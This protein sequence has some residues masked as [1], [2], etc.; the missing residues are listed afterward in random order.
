MAIIA[1]GDATWVVLGDESWAELPDTVR[2]P[3]GASA[4]QLLV[5]HFLDAVPTSEL[6][7]DEPDD[8]GAVVAEYVL[9]YA[10]G[11]RH[12]LPIR[13]RFEISPCRRAWGMQ[14]FAAVEQDT[15]H[16]SPVVGAD[17]D[18]LIGIVSAARG[19]P[20]YLL[21]ALANPNP[22]A[23]IANIEFRA[24]GPRAVTVAALTLCSL[25]NNPFKRSPLIHIKAGIARPIEAEI[26]LG[27]VVKT[28]PFRGGLPD[29]WL[30]RPEIGAG[31]LLQ[32]PPATLIDAVAA[33]DARLTI[34]HDG[35]ESA[36]AWAE[37]IEKGEAATDDGAINLR[38]L[39]DRDTWVH[40]RVIDKSTG[41][42]SPARVSFYDPRGQ[43]LHPY[44]HQRDINI[45]WCEDIGGNFKLG[46][47]SF[48]YVDGR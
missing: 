11:S 22:E 19:G 28:H 15:F 48:A 37:L 6:R 40:V 38:A 26:D 30:D 20:T 32:D 21:T 10:D 35:G 42:E 36:I 9:H 2:V 1:D 39:K 16:T 45:N 27:E 23:E 13:S 24:T 47:T 17:R 8:S 41:Q 25:K 31:E 12:V 4:R 7:P 14:A 33:P 44:G 43:Y 34:R 46:D 29:D 5:C 18:G 3:V